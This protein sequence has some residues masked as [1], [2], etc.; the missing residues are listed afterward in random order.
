M[1]AYVADG[2]QMLHRIDSLLKIGKV[3]VVIAVLSCVAFSQMH[4]PIDEKPQLE[5][6]AK[7]KKKEKGPRA[8]GVLEI[9]SNGRA[10]LIPITIL[11][12]DKWFDAG[13][14]MADPRPMSLESQ[15]VYEGLLAGQPQGLFTVTAAQEFGENWYGLG[16][17][18]PKGADAPKKTKKSNDNAKQKSDDDERPILRRSGSSSKPATPAATTPA[19]TTPP[20]TTPPTTATASTNQET[21]TTAEAKPA[22]KP[23]PKE[24]DEPPNRP[25]L[26][27]GSSGKEQADSIPF[28]ESSVEDFPTGSPEQKNAAVKT[29][30]PAPA[31]TMTLAAISDA[32]GPEPRP[33]VFYANPGERE[34]YLEKMATVASQSLQKFVATRFRGVKAPAVTAENAKLDIYDLTSNNNPVLI[35]T[36]KVPA[37][38]VPGPS[39]AQKPGTPVSKRTSQ[40]TSKK[41]EPLPAAVVPSGLEY[42]VTVVSR[43]DFNGEIHKL[44]DSVTDSSRLDAYPKLDLIDAVDA[45]GDS[46]G[47]LLFRETYDRSHAYIVYRAGMDRLWTLFEGAQR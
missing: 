30:K 13:L 34:T 21:K 24:S 7:A 3:A 44:F 27:R 10:R 46:M 38:Y 17:W 47:E 9:T 6:S 32:S 11:V 43:V 37:N 14:Y 18:K 2:I 19:T 8:L 45:N 16:V 1:T 4:P 20:A 22:P 12:G 41:T 23:A 42:Y 40:T 5:T 25:V 35:L 29:G 28:P 33:Y 39:I 36:A 26:R 31:I 15:T